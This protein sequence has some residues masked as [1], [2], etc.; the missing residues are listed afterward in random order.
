MTV[1]NLA[2]NQ[3]ISLAGILNTKLEK[4]ILQSEVGLDVLATLT[5]H[6]IRWDE[7]SLKHNNDGSFKAGIIT[8]ADISPTLAILG[9]Q[10]ANHQNYRKSSIAN[11]SATAA[12]NGTAVVLTP[13]TGY[14]SMVPMACDV[15]FAGTFGAETVTANITVTFSDNTTASVTKT[16]TAVGT[17]SLTNSDL[18]TLSKDAVYIEQISV[19][20]QSTIASS[21]VT[22]T[23]NHYGLYL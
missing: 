11:P 12:T 14:V 4:P 20:S 9:T 19:V 23:L 16:A 17:A 15:V 6:A 21:A 5:K 7:F 2:V 18:M 1:T 8:T 10:L 3:T 22:V 13:P